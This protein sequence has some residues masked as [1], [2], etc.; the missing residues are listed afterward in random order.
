MLGSAFGA[1]LVGLSPDTISSPSIYAVAGMGAVISCVI[2]API[3][4]ILIAF[5]LTSSYS[6]TTAVML[7]V[8]FAGITTR[9]LFPYSY[10]K[11]QLRR[12]GVDVDTGRETQ[13]LRGRRV[14]DVVSEG[15]PTILPTMTIKQV[16]ALHIDN[17]VT[18][19]LVVDETGVLL[20]QVSVFQVVLAVDNGAGDAHISRIVEAPSLILIVDMDLLQAMRSLRDFVGVSVPVVDGKDTMKLRGVL[21]ENTVINAYTRAVEEDRGDEQGLR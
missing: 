9:R 1:T 11:L 13:I 20:G 19:F 16:Q 8:V 6:V 15:Y 12:R 14:G 5:E 10:F 17:Q 3:A 18:E 7:A 4:T 2:G 21:T